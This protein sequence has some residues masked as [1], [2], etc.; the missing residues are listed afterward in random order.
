M[1]N[2]PLA[3]VRDGDSN[4]NS[5]LYTTPSSNEA[6][7]KQHDNTLLSAGMHCAGDATLCQASRQQTPVDLPSCR[8]CVLHRNQL[9][10]VMDTLGSANTPCW[11]S[12]GG[13]GSA[14]RLGCCEPPHGVKQTRPPL[15]Q[16]VSWN[17]VAATRGNLVHAHLPAA[18]MPVSCP[19]SS[20]TDCQHGAQGHV[21]WQQYRSYNN[22]AAMRWG[23]ALLS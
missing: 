15:L 2:S 9:P 10:A 16:R 12:V 20:H 19:A 7:P 14:W 11:L 23:V 1:T 3:L 17:T 13:L 8:G 18:C 4:T 21:Q 22:Q 5:R 6:S